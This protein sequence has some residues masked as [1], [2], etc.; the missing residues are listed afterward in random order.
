MQ[1]YLKSKTLSRE[2]AYIHRQ[3]KRRGQEKRNRMWSVNYV[4]AVLVQGLGRSY[5]FANTLI[6]VS[7]RCASDCVKAFLTP[8]P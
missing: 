6:A 8:L 3:Q 7:S 1:P 4:Q 5:A 2:T